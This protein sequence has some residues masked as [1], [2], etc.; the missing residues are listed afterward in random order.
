MNRFA[1]ARARSFK[2]A[3]ELA[4][5]RRFKLP[6]IKAGGMDVVDHLK[7]GLIE[8]DLLIDVLKLKSDGSN[9]AVSLAPGEGGKGTLRVEAGATLAELA[10]ILMP[11]LV[12]PQ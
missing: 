6:V 8:P 12:L 4:V 2:E 5:D 11:K 10:T 9:G 7:E 1:I 3:S